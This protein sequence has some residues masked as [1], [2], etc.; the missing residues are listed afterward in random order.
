MFFIEICANFKFKLNKKQV[1]NILKSY[2]DILDINEIIPLYN[3]LLPVLYEYTKPTGIFNIEKNIGLY[4]IYKYEYIIP[5]IITIGDAIDKKVDDYFSEKLFQKGLVLNAMASS[6]LLDIS[7][8]LFSQIYIKTSKMNLGLSCRISPGDNKFP[9]KYQQYILDKL[10]N[11]KVLKLNINKNYVI[12]PPH[13]MTY[14]YMA[15]KK[16]PI[17]KKDH[18]C[19]ECHRRDTCSMRKDLI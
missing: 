17:N 4:N 10:N 7:S 2:G 8:Q 3:L 6:Y 15:D 16:V 13:S 11:N 12:S 14:I 5:C 1:V 18:N 9:L 19:S